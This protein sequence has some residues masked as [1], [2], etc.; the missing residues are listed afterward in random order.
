MSETAI[1]HHPND[2]FDP[3]ETQKNIYRWYDHR[4]S[5]D[6]FNI[7]SADWGDRITLW[8]KQSPLTDI[9][10][11]LE[12]LEMGSFFR[13]DPIAAFSLWKLLQ[14]CYEL[15][16]AVCGPTT[17][18]EQLADWKALRPF[19]Y[20]SAIEV[21][22][23]WKSSLENLRLRIKD[24]KEE[25]K[26]H[27]VSW[28]SRMY[29]ILVAVERFEDAF[30]TLKTNFEVNMVHRE[31][32][33]QWM[34]N[35]IGDEMGE[36]FSLITNLLEIKEEEIGHQNRDDPDAPGK[37]PSPFSLSLSHTSSQF[38]AISPS[39]PSSWRYK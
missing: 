19:K 33:A 28:E 30:A 15:D 37:S 27:K 6:A 3:L 35:T 22:L 39:K 23:E 32:S 4:Y 8:H 5:D 18:A 11:A 16:E 1:L 14:V 12:E 7:Y 17:N 25:A 10:E 34:I 24:P 29:A 26:G 9:D 31:K 13:S 21:R 36:R 38:V 20:L 2:A